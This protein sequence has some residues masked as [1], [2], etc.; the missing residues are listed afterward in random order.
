MTSAWPLLTIAYSIGN[1]TTNGYDQRALLGSC[2]E[3]AHVRPKAED[4]CSRGFE[5][6]LLFTSDPARA[7]AR[8]LTCTTPDLSSRSL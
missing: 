1:N 4:H 3:V 5:A 7:I 2:P 6:S 8:L